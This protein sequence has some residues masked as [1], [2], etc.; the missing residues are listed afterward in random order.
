MYVDGI[1]ED[2]TDDIQKVMNN[3]KTLIAAVHKLLTS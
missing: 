2:D 3:Q 1:D